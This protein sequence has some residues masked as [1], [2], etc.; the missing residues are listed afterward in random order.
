MSVA[1]EKSGK[2]GKSYSSGEQEAE[3]ISIIWKGGHFQSK[4]VVLQVDRT[5]ASDVFS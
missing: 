3:D 2:T 1:R 4:L 5:I